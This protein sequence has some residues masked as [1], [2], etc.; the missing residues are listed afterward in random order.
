MH[1]TCGSQMPPKITRPY[2]YRGTGEDQFPETA[3]PPPEPKPKGLTAEEY[4]TRERERKREVARMKRAAAKRRQRYRPVDIEDTATWG[5]WRHFKPVP[6]P[7]FLDNLDIEAVPIETPEPALPPPLRWQ[8]P[9][10]PAPGWKP[11]AGADLDSLLD[12]L[13]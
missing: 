8:R 3:P 7:V 6:E 11:L 12:E 1:V 5:N 10:R 4:T 9:S 2:V 13:E